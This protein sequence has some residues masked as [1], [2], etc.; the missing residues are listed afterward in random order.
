[1][2]TEMWTTSAR[3]ATNALFNKAL[4]FVPIWDENRIQDEFEGFVRSWGS[5]DLIKGTRYD[6]RKR[7]LSNLQKTTRESGFNEFGILVSEEMG[8]AQVITQSTGGGASVCL[9]RTADSI[10]LC[11]NSYFE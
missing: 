3:K 5:R 6:L 7:V 8:L 10:Y 4:R 2:F 9:W 1:M 11:G